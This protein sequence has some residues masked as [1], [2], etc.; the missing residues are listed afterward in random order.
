MQKWTDAY[1]AILLF[2][3]IFAG[4][5]TQQRTTMPE[6]FTN[7]EIAIQKKMSEKE[8]AVKH[9]Y[10]NIEDGMTKQNILNLLNFS[11]ENNSIAITSDDGATVEVN[12]NFAEYYK[13]ECIEPIYGKGVKI[14]S[15]DFEKISADFKNKEVWVLICDNNVKI[16]RRWS[17]SKDSE[18]NFGYLIVLTIIYDLDKVSGNIVV[19][20][21]SFSKED[22]SE[23][24][25][26]KS[27]F[28]NLREPVAGAVRS[29]FRLA[30]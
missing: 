1:I 14:D 20:D 22:P 25:E 16:K 23:F 28:K 7:V 5:S 24:N 2:V 11:E 26:T 29:A 21:K 4:C 10:I 27:L 15:K 17:V 18:L 12:C 13:K 6:K 30:K 3:C 19:V 9:I 8:K